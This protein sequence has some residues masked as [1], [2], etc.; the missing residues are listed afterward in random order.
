MKHTTLALALASITGLA[1]AQS[2]VTVYGVADTMFSRGS[3]SLTSKSALGS[4]GN[5]TSRIGFR[6]V[7]D[8]GGGLSAGF[9]LESQVALD[10]GAGQGSNPNNQPLATPAADGFS[11]GRR[12]TVSLLG[13]WG[14]VRLG[15]DF[16]AHY[17]NRVEVDPFGNASVGAS[18]AFAGSIGGV[19]STRASNMVGYFLPSSKEG[20]YG[21]VQFYLGENPSGTVTED[22]GNG[23]T[24]RVGY[25]AGP[26]NV[27]LASGRTKYA[28][29]AT[30][31][32]ITSTNLGVQ[33]NLGP[34]KLTTGF[35]QDTV[36]R[37]VKLKADGWILGAIWNV[38][39]GDVKAAVSEYGTDASGNPT[40][41]KLAL[42][43]VHNLSK[44]T[45]L[46]GTLARVS[47]SGKATA[48]LNGSTTAANA[49]S[50]G[51]DIGI[52]HQF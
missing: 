42:G 28:S 12:S 35:Y 17:R 26:L 10:S 3:G 44:R 48:S 52:R 37:T 11:F 43:Y 29:T 8:L 47:N 20:L 27:S 24:V 36:K 4:G 1:S 31:G 21:Q 15:R 51:F 45:A 6:G 16:T 32:D 33:Y 46:Y 41:K 2:S 34:V 5:M 38:G 7:E 30:A 22:D 49:S 13:P 50:T 18:Q 40:T 19:V 25:V 39:S 23:Q 9:N 14:E